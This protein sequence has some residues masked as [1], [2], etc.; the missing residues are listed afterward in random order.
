[1]PFVI[2]WRKEMIEFLKDNCKTMTFDDMAK[3]L[4]V[5]VTSVSHKLEELGLKEGRAM[6]VKRAHEW[7][8]EQLDYLVEHYPMEPVIDI[9]DALGIRYSV[10][11]KRAR[12]LGLK[13]SKDYDRAKVC[14]KR[15]IKGYKH[16][17]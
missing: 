5:S 11:L 2:R 16:I 17:A 3:S 4:G 8:Q 10:V 14:N 6:V 15:Y 12:D 9:A 1:M 7:T 13:K